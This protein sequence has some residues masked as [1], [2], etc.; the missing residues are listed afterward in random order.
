[1]DP[2][3]HLGPNTGLSSG[4]FMPEHGPLGTND[5]PHRSAAVWVHVGHLQGLYWPETHGHIQLQTLANVVTVASIDIHDGVFNNE[6][7]Y[8]HRYL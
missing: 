4:Q 8:I 1:M 7:I 3:L 5:G 6:S 2:T